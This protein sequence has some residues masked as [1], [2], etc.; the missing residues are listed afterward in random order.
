MAYVRRTRTPPWVG[1]YRDGVGER[2]SDTR[3]R[4]FHEELGAR[5]HNICAYCEE[6]ARGEVDHFRPKSKFPELVYE[7]SNWVFA[8]HAC[9]SIFKKDKWPKG[10]YVDPCAPSWNDRPEN[11]FDF[12]TFTGELIPK[13]GLSEDQLRTAWQTISDIG[14]N[15][16]HHLRR[17]L[18]RI[19]LVR[20]LLSFLA[21]SPRPEVERYLE[22]LAERTSELSSI[23]R[24]VLAEFG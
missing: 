12:D 22:K 24:R 9:N 1:Y 2:P 15:E 3:W 11:F 16:R 18:E 14:L 23:S 17:R 19:E 7:W 8:C 13:H 10:G 6:T 4:D 21:D 5:F 20:R